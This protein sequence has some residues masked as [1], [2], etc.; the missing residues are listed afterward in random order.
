MKN[1]RNDKIIEKS[2]NSTG[3]VKKIE[4]LTTIWTSLV[5]YNLVKNHDRL[6]RKISQTASFW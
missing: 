2:N 1:D 6:S 3:D 5:C 4:R